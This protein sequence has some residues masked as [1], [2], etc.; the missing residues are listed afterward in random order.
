MGWVLCAGAVGVLARAVLAPRVTAARTCPKCEYDLTG[1]G[2]KCPECGRVAASETQVVRTLRAKRRLLALAALLALGS[3]AS[4]FGAQTRKDGAL[5]VLPLWV[6]VE[7]SPLIP[8]D[9]LA[10]EWT[11]REWNERSISDED[12][13]YVMRRSLAGN[14]LARRE[15]PEWAGSFGR[16]LQS[17]TL[18]FGRSHVGTWRDVR[19]TVLSGPMVAALEEVVLGQP[20]RVAA[21]THSHWPEGVGI[22][23]T[24]D[25]DS[26]GPECRVLVRGAW[27]SSDGSS[28]EVPLNFP[29][30]VIELEGVRGPGRVTVTFD[31]ELLLHETEGGSPPVLA[32]C[33]EEVLITIGGAPEDVLTTIRRGSIDVELQSALQVIPI[34]NG[35]LVAPRSL[36]KRTGDFDNSTMIVG[37]LAVFRDEQIVLRKSIA[38]VPPDGLGEVINLPEGALKE[39]N[40]DVISGQLGRWRVRLTSDLVTACRMLEDHRYWVGEVSWPVSL[41]RAE[42]SPDE[43]REPN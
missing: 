40:S 27:R 8:T 36:L 38:W 14:V 33:R 43:A 9:V 4:F 2:L 30:E 25:V 5:S 24:A 20:Y 28:G 41:P 22:V 21:H 23:A 12:R 15:D 3:V 29:H 16:L 42:W 11:R 32:T 34:R 35:V 37:T 19:G 17:A 1:L 10:L 18:N 39:L 7:V 31:W 26:W 6:L 13:I